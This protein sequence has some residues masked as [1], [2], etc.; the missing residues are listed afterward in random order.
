[1]ETSLHR[2]LKQLYGGHGSQTEAV[3]RGYRADVLQH[4]LVVEI[5][6]SSLSAIRHKVADLV[7]HGRV[8]VVKPIAQRKLI[9]WGD[10][11]KDDWGKPRQSPK[12]GRLVHVFDEL[13]HFTK[14][15]PHPNLTI[16]VV[17]I[18]EEE[19]RI[20][21]QRRRRFGPNYRL[22]DRRLLRV[23][24]SHRLETPADL[25][26]LTPAD[27]PATFTTTE[28]AHELDCPAWLARKAAYT[29]RHCGATRATGK[30]GNRIVYQCAVPRTAAAELMVAC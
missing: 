15:F 25:L 28:L 23:T 7:Q 12:R 17:L 30:I 4:G 24:S 18:E 21:R 5:Q 29:L 14:V 26:S 20:R 3:V 13:V 9:R 10:P 11:R 8:L 27:L 6:A 19:L 1:M 16:D 2:S 22:H